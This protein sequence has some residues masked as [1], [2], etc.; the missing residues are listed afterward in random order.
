[1]LL[2]GLNWTVKGKASALHEISVICILHAHANK[3][4]FNRKP[5]AELGTAGL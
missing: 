2:H 5:Y 3:S 4:N 1:M